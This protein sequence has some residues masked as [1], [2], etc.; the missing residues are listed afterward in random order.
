MKTQGNKGSLFR[1]H[2]KIQFEYLELLRTSRSRIWQQRKKRNE[3][4]NPIRNKSACARENTPLTIP[5]LG[6]YK[7]NPLFLTQPLCNVYVTYTISSMA[8]LSLFFYCINT[9]IK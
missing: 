3:Q 2:G 9:E 8:H 6:N 1:E 7:R 5:S 4:E